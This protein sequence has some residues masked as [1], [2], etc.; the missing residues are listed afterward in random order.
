MEKINSVLQQYIL[1]QQPTHHNCFWHA[2]DPCISLGFKWLKRFR[3]TFDCHQEAVGQCIWLHDN[4]EFGAYTHLSSSQQQ[5]SDVQK[6]GYVGINLLSPWNRAFLKEARSWN[7][8]L[9]TQFLSRGFSLQ[10]WRKT[11]QVIFGIKAQNQKLFLK[12]KTRQWDMMYQ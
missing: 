7:L 6:F 4:L 1:A 2:E 8:F 11:K 9:F 5:Q 10:P 12:L 3:N